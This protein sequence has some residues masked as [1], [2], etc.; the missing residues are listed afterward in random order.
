[1]SQSGNYNTNLPENSPWGE[2]EIEIY[3]SYSPGSPATYNDPPEPADID[4]EDIIIEN[5]P[6]NRGLGIRGGY[7]IIHEVDDA[8]REI[9][10]TEMHENID[11]D[12][13]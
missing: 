5:S 9:L 10:L 3:Y 6:N 11:D 2:A 12:D 1:M 13:F 8:T 4:I 7:S